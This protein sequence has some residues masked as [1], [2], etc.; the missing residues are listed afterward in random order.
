M[1]LIVFLF[2]IRFCD[3]IISLIR[4]TLTSC[5]HQVCSHHSFFTHLSHL[6]Y[7]LL[8]FFSGSH[9]LL[10]RVVSPLSRVLTTSVGKPKGSHTLLARVVSPLSCVLT[11]S[12]GKPKGL[13]SLRIWDSSFILSDLVRLEDIKK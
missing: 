13:S 7:S 2:L 9:T 10:A 12:V 4:I 8:L 3:F 6:I 5:R 1:L 11:T